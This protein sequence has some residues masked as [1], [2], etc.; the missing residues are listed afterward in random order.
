GA[1]GRHVLKTFKKQDTKFKPLLFAAV[2]IVVLL[3]LLAAFL[4]R[5]SKSKDDLTVLALGAAVLGPPLA[6]AGYTFLPDDELAGYPGTRLAIRAVACG[7]AYALLWGAY[8]FVGGQVFGA[9]SYAKGLDIWQ[10]AVLAV[11]MLAIGAG[12]AYVAFDLDVGS[13]FFHAALYFAVTVI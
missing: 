10:I 6:W 12:I 7:L 1:G 8:G 3:T 4:L 11:P 5:G 9:E 2:A 13:G